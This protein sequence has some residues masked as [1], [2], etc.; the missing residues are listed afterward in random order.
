M[1]ISLITISPEG[2]VWK[3]IRDGAIVSGG[4]GP[5]VPRDKNGDYIYVGSQLRVEASSYGRPFTDLPIFFEASP[6]LER[7]F[8]ALVLSELSR[9]WLGLLSRKPVLAVHLTGYSRLVQ[10]EESLALKECIFRWGNGDAIVCNWPTP[11]TEAQVRE[12]LQ[13][14]VFKKAPNPKRA[15][16]GALRS[17]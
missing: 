14:D 6:K 1:K 16:N 9:K 4:V 13:G 5:E 12:I 8:K 11:Y 2:V 3:T 15:A 17:D 10:T 7:F